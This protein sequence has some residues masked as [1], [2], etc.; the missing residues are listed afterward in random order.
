MTL[1]FPITKKKINDDGSRTI[2][3]K[4][5]GGEVVDRDGQIVDPEWA[6]EKLA[7]W[8][9]DLGGPIRNMHSGNYPPAGKGIQLD[10]EDDGSYIAA[11]IV[12]PTAIKLLDLEV[13]KDLSIGIAEANLYQ[14]SKAPGG[15]LGRAGDNFG[16]VNEVSLVDT[17]SHPDAHILSVAKRAKKKAPIE[18]AEILGDITPDDLL[19]KA[20][21]AQVTKD[22]DKP[23]KETKVA[24][25]MKCGKCKGS[26][27]MDGSDCPDCNGSGKMP[28]VAADKAASPAIPEGHVVCGSCENGKIKGEL[29]CPKCDGKGHYDPAAK[30]KKKKDAKATATKDSPHDEDGDVQHAID[31]ISDGVDDAQGAQGADDATEKASGSVATTPPAQDGDIKPQ[32]NPT[33]PAEVGTRPAAGDTLTKAQRKAAKKAKKKGK[34]PPQFAQQDGGGDGDDDGADKDAPP[35]LKPKKKGKA[36]ATKGVDIPFLAMRAHDLVCPCFSTKAVRKSYGDVT[37]E[38]LDPDWFQRTLAETAGK[39]MAPGSIA[40]ASQA[41]A[42]A[43][44]LQ[45]LAPK[46]FADL[47]RAAH[48]G[49]LDANPGLPN[50]H[51]GLISPDQ[52]RRGFLPG[53]NSDTSS[54]TRVPSPSGMKSP[55]T[56]EQFDR[57]PLTANQTRP[58]LDNSGHSVAKGAATRVKGRDFYTNAAKDEHAGMMAQ[59]HDFIANKFP[60]CCPMA[61]A[62][63]TP[64]DSDGQMGRPAE[65]NG[66]TPVVGNAIDTGGSATMT[67]VTDTARAN[68]ASGD[69]L[70]SKSIEKLVQRAVA[71]ATKGLQRKLAVAER[72]IKAIA[73]SP[74][75]RAD[76]Q[77]IQS[78]GRTPATKSDRKSAER[79]ARAREAASLIREKDSRL[80]NEGLATLR[81]M[82]DHDEIS[83]RAF[84]ALATAD[85]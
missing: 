6:A 22:P 61:G 30:A 40:E 83:P 33:L 59:V 56:A 28:M 47:A 80:G 19:A 38:L 46:T 10:N 78:F 63:G 53:A 41:F 42:A 60:G 26:G 36:K 31:E 15:R 18:L 12:E 1:T 16:W 20:L 65:V 54:T 82:A 34:I 74:D 44:G 72:T 3:G 69:A 8:F 67:A 4:V 43:V 24:K 17:G 75:P 55:L 85:V 68:K 25:G 73:A 45:S 11:K 49:F 48:K 2:Y 77:R 23:N 84:A 37:P 35:W 14:D 58:T 7:D 79:I 21:R 27:Q 9:H 81:D 29:P 13:Y 57:G 51:P 71:K 50:L 70:D 66:S 64:T 76:R 39:K 5:T 52:F 32:T 62:E